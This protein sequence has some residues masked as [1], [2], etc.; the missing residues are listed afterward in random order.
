MELKSGFGFLSPPHRYRAQQDGLVFHGPLG[1]KL[2]P[3]TVRNALIREVLKP[4]SKQFPAAAEE[5]GFADGRLHSFRHYLCS[6]CA[7][8]NVPEQVV[9]EWLGHSDSKMVRHYYHLHDD[10]AQRQ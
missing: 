4:L 2:K 10:E 8:R 7:N 9:K 5:V 1:G 6:T 3:D